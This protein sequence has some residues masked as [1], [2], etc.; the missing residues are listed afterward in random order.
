MEIIEHLNQCLAH[1]QYVQNYSPFTIS[2]TRSAVILF[3]KMTKTENLSGLT[4]NRIE[5]WLMQGIVTGK[6]I[7]RAHV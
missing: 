7:G 6:Q 4:Q 5:D 1:L 2:S 3:V